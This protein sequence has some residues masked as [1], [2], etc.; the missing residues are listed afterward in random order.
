MKTNNNHRVCI[1]KSVLG[2]V[3]VLGSEVIFAKKIP[4][5][6]T[7]IGEETFHNIDLPAGKNKEMML[8]TAMVG[9]KKFVGCNKNRSFGI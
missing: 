3:S 7:I 5:N 9:L 6:I 4:K 8:L 1:Q 2:L